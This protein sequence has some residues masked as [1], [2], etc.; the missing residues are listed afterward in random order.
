MTNGLEVAAAR[1]LALFDS[2]ALAPGVILRAGPSMDATTTAQALLASLDGSAWQLCHEEP[3]ANALGWDVVVSELAAETRSGPL[4]ALVVKLLVGPKAAFLVGT[5]PEGD[6]GYADKRAAVVAFAAHA[7]PAW[8]GCAT[9]EDLLWLP[10]D[11]AVPP[12]WR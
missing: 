6:A 12:Q 11:G 9:L 10:D 8:S 7:S 3:V 2:V 4:R 1:Q 5:L